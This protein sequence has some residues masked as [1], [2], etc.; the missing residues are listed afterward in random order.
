MNPNEHVRIKIETNIDTKI[1][2][3]VEPNIEN[4]VQ[5][6]FA[7]EKTEEEADVDKLIAANAARSIDVKVVDWCA[8]GNGRRNNFLIT[9]P[10]ASSFRLSAAHVPALFNS[11]FSYPA[12]IP[13]LVCRV[14]RSCSMSMTQMGT[15]T[16]TNRSSWP[17]LRSVPAHVHATDLYISTRDGS[18]YRNSESKNCS[19]KNHSKPRS[20]DPLAMHTHTNGYL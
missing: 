14:Y 11:N 5:E 13:S 16:S 4:K 9:T 1:E 19:K 18:C 6:I 12:Q 10:A 2:D 3:K 15:D 7:E 17:R 20:I 8:L